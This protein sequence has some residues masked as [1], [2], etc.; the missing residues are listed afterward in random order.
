MDIR[1]SEFLRAHRE[2]ILDRWE[3]DVRA[4]PK[5]RPLERLLLRDHLP[6]LLERIARLCEERASGNEPPPTP[7]K[8]AEIHAFTR[9]DQGFDLDEVA[10]EYSLLRKRI[11]QL[12]D[13]QP[14]RPAPGEVV[15]LNE[16]LD[17]A[18]AL[19][20][21]AYA[22]FQQRTL[23]AL[24]RISEVAFQGGATVQTVLDGFIGVLVSA[25]AVDSV[26]VLLRHGNVLR[27]RA[28]V[29]L[30]MPSGASV[31][32]GE[33][34]AGKIA[35]TRKPM[36]LR[37]AS[38]DPLVQGEYLRKAGIRALYGLPLS[39]GDEVVGVAHMG[40]K[41]AYDFSDED[42]LLFRAMASRITTVLAHALLQAR[43]RA[44]SAAARAFAGAAT[45]D[46]AI[47]N[48]VREIARSF[49]WDVGMAWKP[50]PAAQVLRPGP[51]WSS[52]RSGAREFEEASAKV[53]LPFGVGLPGRVY[54]SGQ[55]EWVAEVTADERLPRIEAAR[56]A[57][58]HSAIAFPLRAGAE[59]IAV[60]E[61]FS[62]S[63]RAPVEEGAQMTSALRAE[64][65]G[66]LR[67]LSEQEATRRSEAQKAAIL[68]VALD[69]IVSMDSAARVVAWNPAAARMF[70]H[71]RE[72]AVGQFLADLIIPPREREAHWRGLHKYLATGEA[73]YLNRRVETTA[74][75]RDGTEFPVE[76]TI[77]RVPGDGAPWFTGYLRD[78]SKHTEAEIALRHGESQFR[79]LADNIAQ[80]AWMADESG[81]IFWYNKRWFDYTGT[82]LEEMR[83]WGWQKVHH[84]EHLERV[85]G[86]FRRSIE[87][88][89]TWEDTFPLRG[90]DGR[91]RWFLSRAIPIRDE[92]GKIVR[93]F[94]SNT[95]ITE[96]RLLSEAS[97]ELWGFFDLE[98]AFTAVARLLVPTLADACSFH[99]REEGGLRRVAEAHADR[100]PDA[101][102]ASAPTVRAA[103]TGR[104]VVEGSAIAAP[105]ISRKQ[106]LGVLTV[107]FAGDSNRQYSAAQQELVEELARRAA[108][109]VDNARLYHRESD[110]VRQREE[111][112]AI[113]SHDLKNPLGAISLSATLLQREASAS[114][115]DDKKTRRQLETIQRSA[116]RMED[117]IA[118]LLDVGSLQAGRLSIDP[119]PEDPAELV[120]EA[121]ESSEPVARAK[122]IDLRVTAVPRDVAV[123]A[124]RRRMAQVLGNVIGNA[125]KFC[126]AGERVGVSARVAGNEVVFEVA[127]TGPGIRP[128]EVAHL[129]E[130]YWSAA[131]HAKRGTGLGLFIAKGMIDAHHGRIWVESVPAKGSQFFFTLP[132]APSGSK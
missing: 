48:L 95:D 6:E 40:S 45:M 84:P 35:T 36:L 75:R 62:R 114:G 11:L 92:N 65:E 83:G 59:T 112:L 97:K 54:V 13:E 63:T 125:V 56:K 15:F 73:K 87:N 109:A 105:M 120:R 32:V 130:P 47:R 74:V 16:C 27:M 128:D 17:R 39:I 110:A 9:L 26:T 115:S 117:L 94:G 77:T 30:E 66:L 106:L 51:G 43:E 91:Y 131:R 53:E 5:A 100:V 104:S 119:R 24:D 19:A 10:L 121:V 22:R 50:D 127:D 71:S 118:D 122:G 81:S 60:V 31:E 37:C 64:L 113:V 99:L 52:E 1:L 58:L 3:R 79:T 28:V 8:A 96:Q 124:D 25:A 123:L 61:F 132:I 72:E 2:Q 34:F 38:E 108:L 101:P 86:R 33:G 7:R 21:Q 20:L 57:G 103:E 55:A 44:A 18:L 85:L 88:G 116:S 46:D 23:T 67:R 126:R 76:L 98:R 70:G 29:G 93:W 78:I 129:F 107:A 68:E 82:S 49:G 111:M 4:L 12:L 102:A 89:E 14:G 90:K 80:F 41:T 69:G 42:K